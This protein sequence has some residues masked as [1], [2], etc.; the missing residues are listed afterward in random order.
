MILLRSFAPPIFISAYIYK[1][2]FLFGKLTLLNKKK[3]ARSN[4]E[5]IEN[6]I[7]AF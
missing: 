2:F 1:E 5:R 4:S 6:R 3:S 7:N